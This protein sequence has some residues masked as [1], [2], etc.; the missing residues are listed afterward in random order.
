MILVFRRSHS[1]CE[2]ARLALRHLCRA[3]CIALKM[4]T[5]VR[6]RG[7]PPKTSVPTAGAYKFQ[8]N[9]KVA[10]IFTR[11]YPNRKGFI[12]IMSYVILALAVAL[13]TALGRSTAA[14]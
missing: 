8:K 13:M 2:C 14:R 6:L 4:P 10:C 5:Q 11:R 1:V 9:E 3:G 7:T 12:T